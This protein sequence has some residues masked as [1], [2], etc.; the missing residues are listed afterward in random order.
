MTTF[1]QNDFVLSVFIEEYDMPF[2][3]WRK[4][5]IHASKGLNMISLE[6][7]VSL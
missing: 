3:T 1:S 7:K 2:F 5:F 4:L 6:L